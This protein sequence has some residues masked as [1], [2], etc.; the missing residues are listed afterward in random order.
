M[1]RRQVQRWGHRGL[2]HDQA[3][4]DVVDALL[5]DSSLVDLVDEASTPF[6]QRDVVQVDGSISLSPVTEAGAV[7]AIVLPPMLEK[8]VAGGTPD[9]LDM[10]SLGQ[11]L[12]NPGTDFPHVFEV[13]TDM[14][15]G[16]P[17]RR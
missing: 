6:A 13:D 14:G 8:I 4:N 2:T 15:R 17:V 9:D 11:A 3:T 16:G 7:M 5:A 1:H 10:S 12:L